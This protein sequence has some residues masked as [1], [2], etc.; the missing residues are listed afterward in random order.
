MITEAPQMSLQAFFPACKADSFRQVFLPKGVS[1]SRCPQQRR[2]S[3][4]N[5]SV[6]VQPLLRYPS[7]WSLGFWSSFTLCVLGSF[8]FTNSRCIPL[9]GTGQTPSWS[10]RTTPPPPELCFRPPSAAAYLQTGTC[11]LAYS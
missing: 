8:L 6:Y 11:T 4:K 10:S 1:D 2:N 7:G 5:V 3:C 9:T